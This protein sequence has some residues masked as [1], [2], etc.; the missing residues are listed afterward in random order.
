MRLR[1]TMTAAQYREMLLR[2]VPEDA[3]QCAIVEWLATLPPPPLGPYWTAVNPVPGKLTK[4]QAGRVKRLGLRAGAPDI[5]ILWHGRFGGAE[6]KRP[7]G[8]RIGD[9]Q[10]AAHAEIIAAGGF[11]AVV[12]SLSEFLAWLQEVWPDEM[13]AIW[14]RI[15]RVFPWWEKPA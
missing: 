6:C 1:P 11:V 5:F 13:A 14:P 4:A 15:P 3:V 12:R 9:A 2:R 8:G 10:P 7:K